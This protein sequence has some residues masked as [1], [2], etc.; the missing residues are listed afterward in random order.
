MFEN[1]AE[2]QK[3]YE[4][5]G[6]AQPFILQQDHF[7]RYAEH[8]RHIIRRAVS[9]ERDRA[10]VVLLTRIR[11]QPFVHGW[12]RC[13]RRN[14]QHMHDQHQR[15]ES[16]EGFTESTQGGH[17]YFDLCMASTALARGK[18]SVANKNHSSPNETLNP[19]TKPS[20]E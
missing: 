10:A 8:H 11:M 19:P 17:A 1:P 12:A 2:T 5:H 6:F 14:Q 9:E 20:R 16:R 4:P 13:C 18:S 3:S 15:E 7:R